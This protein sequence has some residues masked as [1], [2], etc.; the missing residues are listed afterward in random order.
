MKSHRSFQTLA[1]R[2]PPL[3]AAPSAIDTRAS[4]Y[5]DNPADLSLS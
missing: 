2:P 4:S 3:R 5:Q 1:R